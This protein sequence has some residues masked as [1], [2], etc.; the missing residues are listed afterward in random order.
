MVSKQGKKD[1]NK[2][3]RMAA[4]AF[5][6][7]LSYASEV[8][9]AATL[10]ELIDKA[11]QEGALSAT[12]TSSMTGRT[13]LK[14]ADAFKKRFGLN[15][16]VTITPLSGI[17]SASRAIAETKVGTVPM[18]D[19]QEAADTSHL[20]LM[21]AGGLQKIDGWELLLAEIYTFA[22]SEKVRPEQLSPAPFNGI[23]FL[24]AVRTK[25]LVYNPRLI[26]KEKL[27]KTHAELTDPK[28]KDIWI[29]PPW[30]SHWDVGPLVFPDLGEEKW[31]EI[32]RKASKN[33]GAV[34]PENAGVQRVLLGEYAFVPANSY[35]YF[36][37]KSKDLQAPLEITFFKDYNVMAGDLYAVRKG[38]R[39]PAAATLFSLWIGTQEA[40]AIWQPDLFITQYPWGESALDKREKEFIQTS[41]GNMIDP[42]HTE[43]GRAY[44]AWFGTE[45]GRKFRQAIGKAIKGE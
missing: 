43:K 42:L 27:P 24:Y 22:R 36:A 29:Q 34:M 4:A 16:E 1:S 33:V 39:H 23:S 3:A 44:L 37:A 5:L 45:E 40:K 2:L 31:L 15:I 6:V 17:E 25:G 21:G 8:A 28:Y 11:K 10:A 35:Y 41:G 32:V 12:V 13:T 14:L 18:Y 30:T 26:S 7:G 38:A 19:T 9:Y 20:A